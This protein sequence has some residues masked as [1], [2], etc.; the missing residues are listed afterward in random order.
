MQD[1]VLLGNAA[2][3]THDE[4]GAELYAL[5]QYRTFRRLVAMLRPVRRGYIGG[6]CPFEHSRVVYGTL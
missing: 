4:A 6:C 3:D 1:A 2:V 5:Y